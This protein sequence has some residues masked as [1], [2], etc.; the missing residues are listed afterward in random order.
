MLIIKSGL[1]KHNIVNKKSVDI[2]MKL[3]VNVLVFK[4]K[5]PGELETD[6][7]H[8]SFI[9]QFTIKIILIIVLTNK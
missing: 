1:I 9:T 5:K 8:R 3:L 4:Y 7:R 6:L 2:R